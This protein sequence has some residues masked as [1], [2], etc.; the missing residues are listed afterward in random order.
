MTLGPVAC[1]RVAAL[2]ADRQPVSPGGGFFN[3]LVLTLVLVPLAA[4]GLA[5]SILGL[6]YGMFVLPGTYPEQRV[7]LWGSLV[8][9]FLFIWTTR[10][11]AELQ[12]SELIA[13]DR[14]LHLPLT[15]KE[16]FFLNYASSLGSLPIVLFLPGTI[17][18]ALG[19]V[20]G[21]GPRMLLLFPML[22]GF[23]LMVTA[24]TYQLKG[25][26]ATLMVNTQRRRA[27]VT[28][29]TAAFLLLAQSPFIIGQ[30]FSR[31][32]RHA[33]GHRGSSRTANRESHPPGWSR[34]HGLAARLVRVRGR[35]GGRIANGAS[36]AG[37]AR[38]VDHR[39]CKPGAELPHDPPVP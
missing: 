29:V 32:N 19:S 23:L 4:A 27:I 9:S 34:Q 21:L 24:V 37:G 7:F 30:A 14:L 22:C 28:F 8:W 38:Y 17:G 5:L 15:L 33:G 35:C 20:I 10:F 1:H 12:R 31:A 6:Y 25:W 11:V 39:A 3:A 18:L 2:A 16:V 13:L 36:T 26:L